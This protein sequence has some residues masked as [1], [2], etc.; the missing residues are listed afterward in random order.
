MKKFLFPLL[1]AFALLLPVWGIFGNS[2]AEQ[3]TLAEKQART[4]QQPASTNKNYAEPLQA[5]WK[6]YINEQMQ[7]SLEK[8]DAHASSATTTL[9]VLAAILFGF[10][11][12]N[13][14]EFNTKVK[15]L[16]G[17]LGKAEKNCKLLNKS[18]K[19]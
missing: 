10:M 6:L 16:E 14:L 12:F 1:L 9:G 15:D 4:G 7:A 19:R 5:E 3:Q 8:L 11:I 17:K 18:V 13:Y 2:S